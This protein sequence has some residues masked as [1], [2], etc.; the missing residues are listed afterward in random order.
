MDGFD[1][2]HLC[3]LGCEPPWSTFKGLAGSQK[4]EVEVGRVSDMH[5][6]QC[7][8]KEGSWK[9]LPLSFPIIIIIRVSACINHLCSLFTLCSDPNGYWLFEV[10]PLRDISL[11]SSFTLAQYLFHHGTVTEIIF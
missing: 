6:H 7:S 9:F 2:D 11:L 3:H 1:V 10:R 5:R 4:R 8:D